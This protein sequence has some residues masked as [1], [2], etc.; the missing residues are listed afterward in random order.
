MAK[1]SPVDLQK[2]LSGADYPADRKSLVETA[3]KNNAPQELT[4]ELSHLKEKTFNTPAEVSKA[5]FEQR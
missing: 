4:E 3:K 1:I 5:V 2:A